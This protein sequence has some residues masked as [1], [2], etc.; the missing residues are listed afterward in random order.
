M[1]FLE[2]GVTEVGTNGPH[3]GNFPILTVSEW[4][5]GVFRFPL[6]SQLDPMPAIHACWRNGIVPIPVFAR[7]SFEYAGRVIRNVESWRKQIGADIT[8]I[9]GPNE[10][11]AVSTP[12]GENAGWEMTPEDCATWSYDIRKWFPK[13]EYMYLGPSFV[14]GNHLWGKDLPWELYDA[15]NVHPYNK[16][17]GSA[18]LH[19]MLDHYATYQKPLV[20][21]EVDSRQRG[22]LPD[23]VQR[24]D[25]AMAIT[26][27]AQKYLDFGLVNHPEA[28]KEYV[29]VTGGRFTVPPEFEYILGF[30][31]AYTRN[32]E[33]V[34]APP[35]QPEFWPDAGLSTQRTPNGLL[36]WSHAH[37]HYFFANDGARYHMDDIT[38]ELVRVG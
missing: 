26:F 22:L 33:L 8:V 32:P 37:G 36:L 38:H 27:C 31:K 15:A 2:A 3:G 12:G 24:A 35:L 16:Q 19:T 9:E 1:R 7:E 10:P 25:V 13:G 4:G 14:S 30:L 20:I 11:D 29:A 28:L 34:G 17:A 21:T 23:L 18:A 6:H 5:S